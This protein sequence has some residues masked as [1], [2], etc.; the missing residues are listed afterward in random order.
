MIAI[1]AQFWKIVSAIPRSGLRCWRWN[2]DRGEV[3]TISERWSWSQEEDYDRGAIQKNIIR[4][5]RVRIAI[6][7]MKSRSQRYCTYRG[8]VNAIAGKIERSRRSCSDLNVMI[9]IAAQ[10]WKIVSAIPRLGLRCW[11]WNR[12]RG[13]VITI[14]ARWSWSQEEDYDRGAIQKNIIRDLRVRM[15]K[16]ERSWRSYSDLSGMIVIAGRWSRSRRQT[17]FILARWY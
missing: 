16:I 11:R 17:V 1:T 8:V 13:G 15:V 6:L 12:D 3:I 10:F 14:S 4:D 9:A 7:A 2:C 5:L